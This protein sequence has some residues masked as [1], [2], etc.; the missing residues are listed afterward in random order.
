[1]LYGVRSSIP[2]WESFWRVQHANLYELIDD[3]WWP[4]PNMGNLS[5][6]IQAL[7]MPHITTGTQKTY[8][9][10]VWELF[11]P[12]G[13]S[14]R[15]AS[16]NH[17]SSSSAWHVTAPT[18]TTAQLP[19]CN[20][21]M[22]SGCKMMQNIAKCTNVKWTIWNCRLTFCTPVGLWPGNLSM[23]SNRHAAVRDIG[24]DIG[25]SFRSFKLPLRPPAFFLPLCRLDLKQSQLGTHY[26]K[27]KLQQPPKDRQVIK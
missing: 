8:E 18:C 20:I 12:N 10:M 17:T 14:E 22:D 7:A 26:R 25:C 2:S 3:D 1:M 11:S 19:L 24:C 16:E 23:P 27:N 15:M 21:P 13:R 4:Y 6:F 9:P 5:S